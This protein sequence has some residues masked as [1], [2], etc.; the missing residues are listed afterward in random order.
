[1][2][3]TKQSSRNVTRRFHDDAGVTLFEIVVALAITGSILLGIGQIMRSAASTVNYTATQSVKTSGL[4]LASNSIKNEIED[5]DSF[6]ISPTVGGATT[7]VDADE[8]TTGTGTV[9]GQR[10]VFPLMTTYY[11]QSKT[12]T[13]GFTAPQYAVGFEVRS[14]DANTQGELW[15]VFCNYTIDSVTQQALLKPDYS[16]STRLM[17]DLSIP[18]YLSDPNSP[19]SLVSNWLVSPNDSTYF[20]VK[21]VSYSNGYSLGDCPYGTELGRIGGLNGT[22]QGLVLRIWSSDGGVKQDVIAG[23][24]M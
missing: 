21:C 12:G 1:M 18:G 7:N 20:S 16:R 19:N 13:V 15:R 11:R 6:L 9:I 14:N 5:A 22:I 4:A 10:G 3:T 24:R 2:M 17:T 23:R 8:C